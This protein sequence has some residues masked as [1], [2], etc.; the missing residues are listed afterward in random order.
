MN[1][2]V[3][4]ALL[5]K[6]GNFDIATAPDGAEA[7]R[8][9]ENP[10]GAPFDLVLTDMWMPNLDGE[11]LVKAIRANPLLAPIRVIAVTADV[12]F[13]DKALAAGFNGILLKPIT[14]ATLAGAL[15]A[16]TSALREG[17][18]PSGAGGSPAPSPE[19]A[20]A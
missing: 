20:T 11:G 2:M 8:I 3:L 9:L 5:G 4:K 1:L 12:E 15:P 13:K 6:L 16:P 17:D 7:L 14:L 19:D 18:G 10:G